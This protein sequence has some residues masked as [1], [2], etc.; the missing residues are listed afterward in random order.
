MNVSLLTNEEI[1]FQIEGIENE[2][3]DALTSSEFSE[4]INL[5]CELRGERKRRAEED[6]ADERAEIADIFDFLEDEEIESSSPVE[7]FDEENFQFA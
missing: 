5:L 4:Q 7:I 2:N 1:D 6:R 3:S